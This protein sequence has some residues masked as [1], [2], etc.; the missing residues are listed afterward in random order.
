MYPLF[1][2]TNTIMNNSGSF[3]LWVIN[4]EGGSHDDGALLSA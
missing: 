4:Q 2:H 1:V 3:I